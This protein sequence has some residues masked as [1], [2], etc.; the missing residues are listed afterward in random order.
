PT[1]NIR[2]GVY[3]DYAEHPLPLLHAA[4]C[5][6]TVNADD[7]TLFGATLNDE[8]AL[9]GDRFGL[10]LR[11]IDEVLLNTVRYSFLPAPRRQAL[12]AECRGEM[13][14]LQVLHGVEEDRHG[15]R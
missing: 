12:E 13:A 3:H 15:S 14:A 6:V 8:V 10:S 1:S 9:L 4:G 11:A 2:L 5:V 7:S